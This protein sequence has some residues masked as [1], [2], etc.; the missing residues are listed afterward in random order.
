MVSVFVFASSALGTPVIT[1]G[2]HVLQPDMANQP[3]DVYVSGGDPVFGVNFNIEVGPGGPP[4]Q[5]LVIFDDA[6]PKPYMFDSPNNT[7]TADLDGP[8]M[9]PVL[10]WEGRN[11]TTPSGTIAATGLLGT[12]FFDTTGI[13]SGGPWPLRMSSTLN[14]PT[15]FAGVA[16]E[17]TDGTITIEGTTIPEPSTFVLWLVFCSLGLFG[18]TRPRRMR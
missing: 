16:T 4:I 14:G 7:G 10:L 9:D 2:N 6:G 17:I 5:D 11:T 15:D 8:H 3:V 1:I 18:R 12:V 13:L